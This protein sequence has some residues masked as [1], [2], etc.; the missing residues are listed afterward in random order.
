M[1]ECPYCGE[2]MSVLAGVWV[3][4]GGGVQK[5]V[6][7]FVCQC[8]RL[9]T[10]EAG[11]DWGALGLTEREARIMEDAEK[12]ASNFKAQLAETEAQLTEV[13]EERNALLE[14]VGQI[15]RL[16]EEMEAGFR[17]KDLVIEDLK[18][19]LRDGEEE[20]TTLREAV[21]GLQGLVESQAVQIAKAQADLVVAGVL[22]PSEDTE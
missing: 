2:P 1:R 13:V 3:P 4:V 16:R 8:G 12:Y 20:L 6:K 22:M 18:A 14:R 19:L 15:D 9:F 21:V 7:G 10:F 17:Q 5:K 11:E